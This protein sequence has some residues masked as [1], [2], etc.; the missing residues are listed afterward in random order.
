MGLR[1]SPNSAYKWGYDPSPPPSPPPSSTPWQ[2]LVQP[3]GQT[4]GPR[5]MKFGMH[6]PNG[7]PYGRFSGN[8]KIRIFSPK[9]CVFRDLGLRKISAIWQKVWYNPQAKSFGLQR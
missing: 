2:T 4:M 5:W 8:F 6:L 1:K 7:L 3:P 9:I